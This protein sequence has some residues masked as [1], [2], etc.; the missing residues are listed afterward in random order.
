MRLSNREVKHI[1]HLYPSEIQDIC[2]GV[3]ESVFS[4]VP[5]VWERPKMGGLAYFKQENSTPLKGM[6]CHLMPAAER[7]E[8]GF[9]FGAFMPDPVNL[10]KGK[11]KAKRILT[12]TRYQDVPWQALEDLIHEAAIIDPTKFS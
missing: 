9:I 3:R 5:N 6:I 10:L 7:V 2:C 11:Q 1:L 8:I 4:T 12:L